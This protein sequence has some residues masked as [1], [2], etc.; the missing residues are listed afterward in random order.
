MLADLPSALLH[1]LLRSSRE[2]AYPVGP[3]AT[4]Y[5]NGV[6]GPPLG[7]VVS[8]RIR[9]SLSAPNG[10]EI[11][12][13]YA[14]RGALLGVA[15]LVFADGATCRPPV[16]DGHSFV[17][18]NR[19][20]V[21]HPARML[22][23]SPDHVREIARQEPALTWILAK[24]IA[25]QAVSN[26]ELVAAN[27]FTPIRSRVARHLLKL[28]VREGTELVLDVSQQEIA[29]A[30]GSVREVVARTMGEFI[31]EG[32]LARRVKQLVV[33]DARRLQQLAQAS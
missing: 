10:R 30:I 6:I 3:V 17:P 9:L 13:Q 4:T 32:T 18:A 23:L 14:E 19:A 31:A 12:L 8:G 7:L 25:M 20:E 1:R 16:L 22:V 11:A 21:T 29:D 5:G 33:V 15:S 27:V 26:S 24:A 2:R 28:A